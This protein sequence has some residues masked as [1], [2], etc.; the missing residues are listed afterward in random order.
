M[1]IQYYST[2]LPVS[3]RSVLPLALMYLSRERTSALADTVLQYSTRLSI[4]SMSPTKPRVWMATTRARPQS[5]LT[6]NE[7]DHWY[8]LRFL[9]LE[10]ST[11]LTYSNTKSTTGRSKL[12]SFLPPSTTDL[13]SPVNRLIVQVFVANRAGADTTY[14]F[15]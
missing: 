9:Y 7:L 11:S 2:R 3:I 10:G 5:T 13:A 14:T 12:H 1:Y 15:R 8:D 6:P 4:V